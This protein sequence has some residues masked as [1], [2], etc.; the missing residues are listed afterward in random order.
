M[1][2]TSNVKRVCDQDLKVKKMAK[3]DGKQDL[4]NNDD[5]GPISLQN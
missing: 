5:E 1:Y 3:Q 2:R 4:N